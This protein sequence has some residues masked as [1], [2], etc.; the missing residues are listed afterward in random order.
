MEIAI[1]L[2]VEVGDEWPVAETGDVVL[3]VLL[4]LDWGVCW[5]V[6]VGEMLEVE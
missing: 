5:W 2:A 6:A 1:E 3:E 4:P